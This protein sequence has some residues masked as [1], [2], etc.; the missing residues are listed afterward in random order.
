MSVCVSVCLPWQKANPATTIG[1]GSSTTTVTTTSAPTTL[2]L[3]YVKLTDFYFKNFTSATSA[4][5]AMEFF[6]DLAETC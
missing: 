6:E 5:S 3:H 4:I 1:D 2:L